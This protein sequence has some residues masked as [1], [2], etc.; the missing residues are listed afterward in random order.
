MFKLREMGILPPSL[1]EEQFTEASVSKYLLGKCSSHFYGP[2]KCQAYSK[3]L[4]SHVNPVMSLAPFYILMSSPIINMNHEHVAIVV[5][6]L[7]S[8]G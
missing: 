4:N 1:L 2:I 3:H 7:H 8:V 6:L 5:T